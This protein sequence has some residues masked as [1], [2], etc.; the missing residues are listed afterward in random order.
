MQLQHHTVDGGIR[1]SPLLV[2]THSTSL[3]ANDRK[4]AT[5]LTT[6][7]EKDQKQF[8]FTRFGPKVLGELLG[9]V[10]G[11]VSNVYL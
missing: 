1:N 4:Q 6:R 7:T 9:N 8:F 2:I 11:A 10:R 3:P 5:N